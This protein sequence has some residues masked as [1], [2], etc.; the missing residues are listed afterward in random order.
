MQAK[1]YL[2]KPRYNENNS[3]TDLFAGELLN[4]NSNDNLINVIKLTYQFK[5]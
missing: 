5:S 3:P 1:K 4:R 2:V